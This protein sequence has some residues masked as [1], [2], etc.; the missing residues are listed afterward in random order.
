MA[1]M[2]FPEEDDQ[3]L[4]YLDED[5]ELVQP[6][7]YVPIIPMVLVNGT[8]PI[9][10][11]HSTG[12]SS[13]LSYFQFNSRN[14]GFGYWLEYSDSSL[15]SR[16]HNRQHPPQDERRR[17]ATHVALVEG[18]YRSDPEEERVDQFR[19]EGLYRKGKRDTYYHP[20]YLTQSLQPQ[21][22]PTTVRIT[23][24]PVKKWTSVYKEFLDEMVKPPNRK[25]PLVKGF[26][27]HHSEHSV[28]FVVSL[29]K[30]LTP[31]NIP[32]PC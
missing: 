30:Y 4:N 14:G 19:C 11:F 18:I 25:R 2:V 28:E 16:G 31:Q 5:G 7:Y 21:T 29:T 27:E 12:H 9:A 1:R 32:M 20:F 10:F 26:K 6:D 17:H 3:L 15:Q 24:L 23:E 13:P 22:G 8:L